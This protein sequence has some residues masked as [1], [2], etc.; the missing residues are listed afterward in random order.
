M[1]IL[2]SLYNS[3]ADSYK[4]L[5]LAEFSLESSDYNDDDH[6]EFLD[7]LSVRCS[8]FNPPEYEQSEY[9]V[10]F[11]NVSIPKPAPKISV[12]RNFKL[13][14]RLDENYN[15]YKH[16][17]ELQKETFDYAN[18]VTKI[19]INSLAKNGKLLIVKVYSMSGDMVDV[20][21]GEEELTT[22]LL[23]TY[24]K[25]W[26]DNITL[27]DYSH[28]NSDPM[29]VTVSVNYITMNSDVYT[30]GTANTNTSST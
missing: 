2:T 3:G 1:N 8:D 4:N 15:I 25:C 29:T 24:Y 11:M 19:D 7:S 14:F 21:S 6:K 28:S 10:K 26:I 16:L 13:T 20:D 17:L 22:K 23:F 18:S 12:T 5:F 30:T 27:S 9:T